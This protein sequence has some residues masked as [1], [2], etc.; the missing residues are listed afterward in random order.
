MQKVVSA[1]VLALLFHFEVAVADPTPVWHS[2]FYVEFN[3][4]TPPAA[5]YRTNG[6]W[7]Y[8]ATQQA[9]L[10]HR[11][12]GAGDRYCA[13]V[14]PFKH[15]PCQHLVNGGKRYLVFPH[16]KYC[17][18]CCDA[19][20]GCGYVSPTWLDDAKFEGNATVNGAAVFKWSKSGLQPNYYYST[21]DSDQIP[22]EL[23]Q[24]PTDYQAFHPDTFTTSP[25][26]PSVFAVP[27]Y[28][29]SSCPWYSIC[30]A[31][32]RSR[33]ATSVRGARVV[34]T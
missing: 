7:W 16:K 12:S 4:T 10:I 32:G 8:D 6:K 19:A 11:D 17:C 25:I 29:V 21:A 24:L 3:E 20:H 22:I 33:M 31:I 9:E 28:C 13:T 18:M 14:Y 23:D 15:T 30:K 27:D 2:T 34:P 26:D 5:N 1:I